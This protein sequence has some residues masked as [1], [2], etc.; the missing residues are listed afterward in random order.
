M[1]DSDP[2]RGG[3]RLLTSADG[4]RS[5]RTRTTRPGRS[6]RTRLESLATRLSVIAFVI[7][8]L[9]VGV[10]IRGE[11]IPLGGE[12]SL[13][14]LTGWW[15]ALT[16][17]LGFGLSYL[18]A[19]RRTELAW[20]RRLPLVKRALDLLALTSAVALVANIA[21]HAIFQV[22]QLGFL[23]LEVDWLGGAALAGAAASVMTYFAVVIGDEVTSVVVVGL[24]VTGLFMGTL[25]SMIQSPEATWW[26]FHFS[27]L[28]ND[29][30]VNGYQFN[31]SLLITG[32]LLTTLANFIGRDIDLGLRHRG[33]REPGRVTVLTWEFAAIGICM[34]VVGLVPDAVNFPV[35]VSA[36]A[37][38]V[39]AFVAFFLTLL[40]MI[41]GLP[42]DFTA[43]SFTVIAAIAVSIAL[44]VPLGYYN[45]TGMET[46]AAGVLF[47]WL[48]LLA[49]MTRAYAEPPVT[50]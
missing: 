37:G 7:V 8:A 34:I 33:I 46:M 35:H 2:R 12:D 49:R 18:L 48:F 42:R 30:G 47:A 5:V 21:M 22:F 1:G 16:A 27:R 44:W 9:G 50:A 26:Q 36:G 31:V 6:S 32:L 19:G 43:T 29:T 24:V 4:S 15:T 10:S 41:P 13:G 39:V 38:M 25:A 3:P 20:R 17:G 28:G 23:G 14:A 40:R 11:T 45:L